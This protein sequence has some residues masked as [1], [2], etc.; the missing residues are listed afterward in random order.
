MND[1]YN[2]IDADA[3]E[4][5]DVYL[6]DKSS[7]MNAFLSEEKR[8]LGVGTSPFEASFF[9]VH[10]A[11]RGT[12]RIMLAHDKMLSVP[13][14]V[15]M[16]GLHHE[17]AHTVLHG[18]LEYYLFSVPSS[19]LERKSLVSRQVM[20]DL[21]YL[22]SVAVKDYEVTRLLCEKGFV[23]DQVAYNRYFL[24][25]SEEDYEAWNMAKHDKTAR[26]LVLVSLLKTIFCAAPIL[27]DEKY[28]R[29]ISQC[30]AMSLSHLP[31]DMSTRLRRI[32]EV[33]SKFG[34]N[35]HENVDLLMRELFNEFIS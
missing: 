4:I 5:V 2:R 29:E 35:T 22:V 12:P 13:R 9:A 15:S 6:F 10:D 34:K 7:S 20:R 1:C 24:E 27:T 16:G 18:S 19:L 17:V 31:A 30:I 14:L 3:V 11:W 28:R 26:F 8:S 23:E 25:P 32:L 21:L 33:S